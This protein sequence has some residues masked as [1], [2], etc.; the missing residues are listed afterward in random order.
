MVADFQDAIIFEKQE[1]LKRLR[2]EIQRIM[3]TDPELIC[4][5]WNAPESYSKKEFDPH[6][7]RVANAH[8]L[9]SMEER[10]HE[11]SID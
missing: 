7:A 2:S 8:W 11:N 10:Q 3:L 5:K 9:R 4:G 1:K 6:L